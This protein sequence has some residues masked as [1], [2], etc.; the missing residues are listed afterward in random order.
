MMWKILLTEKNQML[1]K[2]FNPD[3]QNTWS[4]KS[5]VL[6]SYLSYNFLEI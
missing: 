4:E 6:L 1:L 3:Y 2:A 5:Q